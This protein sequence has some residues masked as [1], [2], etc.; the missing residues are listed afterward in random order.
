MSGLLG[1]L[2][3]AFTQNFGYKAVALLFA[4]V[5]WI[6]V[7]SEQRVEDRVRAT[8]EWR[9]PDGTAL[10]EPPLEQVS[11]SVEGVQAF[12]R[13]LKQRDL[14]IVVDLEKAREGDVAV[15]L[16]QKPVEGLPTQVHVR[17]VSPA[18][19]RV[20]LDRRLKRKVG[21]AAVTVGKVAEGYRV[22]SVKL[23]PERAEFEGA[24]SVLR[25]L[26]AV[27]TEDIDLGGLKEDVDLDI[28]LSLKKGITLAGTPPRFTAH[29]DVEPIITERT[30]AEVPVLV[31]DAGWTAGVERMSV[32]LSGPAEALGGLGAD[33]VSVMVYVPD[34]FAGNTGEARAGRTDG[35]RFEVVHGGGDAVEVESWTPAV[36]PVTRKEG[37]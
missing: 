7:Q 34:D 20:T 3:A 22:V 19:L 25:A 1:S 26:D 27:S 2:R 37:G 24:A 14:K 10:T 33:E 31:R 9:L 23:S 21:V 32:A 16:S 28:G 15:D 13:L 30:F 12:V 5:F 18:Q 36:I 29:I 8:V 17:S 35:L 4:L 6:W 11:L